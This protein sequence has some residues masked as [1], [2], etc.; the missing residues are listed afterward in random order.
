MT[1]ATIILQKA[2]NRYQSK[3][4]DA[5]AAKIN[6]IIA[7]YCRHKHAEKLQSALSTIWAKY[8]LI[9]EKK[10]RSKI[11]QQRRKEEMRILNKATQTAVESMHLSW[12]TTEGKQ[13]FN[14][15]KEK[16]AQQHIDEKHRK[17]EMSKEAREKAHVREVFDSFDVD[18]SGSIDRAELK[19]IL[20]ELCVPV[21]ADYLEQVLSLSGLL[22]FHVNLLFSLLLA[23]V[24]CA[25]TW[26]WDAR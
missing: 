25:C 3:K 14:K 23:S 13:Q 26:I 6:A 4:S 8:W 16:I 21:T 7:R 5:A 12:T 10:R 11:E 24:F 9:T 20:D 17:K 2:F 19:I 22:K 1:C 15:Q 18:S